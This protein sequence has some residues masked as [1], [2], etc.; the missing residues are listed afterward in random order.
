[1]TEKPDEPTLLVQ[2][3][4]LAPVVIVWSAVLYVAEP[5]FRAIGAPINDFL[6][7]VISLDLGADFGPWLAVVVAW[8]LIMPFWSIYAN[9]AEPKVEALLAHLRR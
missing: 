6:A 3:G 4:V 5:L 9:W 1:M 8:I 2:L 7:R